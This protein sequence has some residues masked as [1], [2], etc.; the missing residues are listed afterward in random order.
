MKKTEPNNP[1][2][3]LDP[4]LDSD[5][6]YEDDYMSNDDIYFLAKRQV[7]AQVKSILFQLMKENK[8]SKEILTEVWD[9]L[10]DMDID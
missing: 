9:R 10:K 5:P 6:F 4:D 2:Y 3:W 1:L 8:D 7:I